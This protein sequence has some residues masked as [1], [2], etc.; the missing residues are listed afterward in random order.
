MA[1]R[2]ASLEHVLE[3]S[4][5]ESR[6]ASRAEMGKAMRAWAEGLAAEYPNVNTR[7]GMVGWVRR[8]L[9]H[10]G[11]RMD[12]ATLATFFAWLGECGGRGGEPAIVNPMVFLGAAEAR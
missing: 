4:E 9:K 11:Y 7:I 1:N 5:T 6:K 2:A 3:L 10:T 8:C 12:D